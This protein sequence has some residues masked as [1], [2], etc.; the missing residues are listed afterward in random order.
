VTN[1][2][3]FRSEPD[4]TVNFSDSLFKPVKQ[5]ISWVP[6]DSRGLYIRAATGFF[7]KKKPRFFHSLV[8]ENGENFT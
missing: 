8:L 1:I 4:K 2:L 3:W 6:K 5:G 7:G